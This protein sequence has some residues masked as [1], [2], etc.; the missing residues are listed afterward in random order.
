MKTVLFIAEAVTL[1]HVARPLALSATLN[2]SDYRVHFATDRQHQWLLGDFAGDF[3]P[4]RSLDS[5]Q[6]LQRLARGK[7]V[8]DDVTLVSHVEDD[9]AL[10]ASVQ[11][12]L[13]VGDF[14]LSLSI[15]ARLAKVPY[16]SLSNAYWS[17][18]HQVPAYP[19]PSL[20][21]TRVLPIAAATALFRIARPLAFALHSRPLNR[22]RKKYGLPPLPGD[23][24]YAYTDADRVLYA[25]LPELFPDLKLPDRHHWLGPILWSPPIAAPTWWDKL[26]AG[27]PIVYVTLGSSGQSDLLP[28]LLQA[29]DGLELTAIVATAGVDLT[30][31]LPDNAYVARYLPGDRAAERA[32]LVI[33]NGGSP[34]SQQAL[35]AGVPVLG[36]AGNL[37]QFLNMAAIA[38]AGAG[39]TLRADRLDPQSVRASVRQL[40]A[41]D[42]HR[43][44]AR[45]LSESSKRHSA[46]RSFGERVASEL[47]PSHESTR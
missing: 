14:R 1:A 11:P 3:S 36:I 16:F 7:P 4:L 41:S 37:D 35:A 28:L 2:A 9:L 19:V 32:S 39:Y 6:F 46:A 27:R 45:A 47:A 20:P 13:V 17:P 44:A 10:L 42:S 34:T 31:P 8:Y 43:R 25:D 23:L 38:R 30:G 5:R 12:D 22:V 24:R 40:L 26:P 15:S 21:L 29:L 33:C 18:S